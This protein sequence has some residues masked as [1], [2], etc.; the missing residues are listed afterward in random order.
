MNPS[1][2]CVCVRRYIR[3]LSERYVYIYQCW[4]SVSVCTHI[5]KSSARDTHINIRE[6]SKRIQKE[7]LAER[8]PGIFLAL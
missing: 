7:S 6:I 3:K 1:V 2:G 4:G 8:V 5:S